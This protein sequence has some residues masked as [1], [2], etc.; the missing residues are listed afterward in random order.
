MTHAGWYFSTQPFDLGVLIFSL[1][2]K[3]YRK[4]AELVID[5]TSTKA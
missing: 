5:A 1:L 2:S 3:D 4:L